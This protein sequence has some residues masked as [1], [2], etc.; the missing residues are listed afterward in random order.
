MRISYYEFT[1]CELKFI[2]FANSVFC[3]YCDNVD[4][5]PCFYD[6]VICIELQS[7]EE[8]P[9]Q[10]YFSRDYINENEMNHTDM[11]AR[12]F[13]ALVMEL[14]NLKQLEQE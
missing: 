6:K 3:L 1:S 12:L 2:R 9:I 14:R 13:R 5:Y 7:N 4:V 8:K 10:L 11:T